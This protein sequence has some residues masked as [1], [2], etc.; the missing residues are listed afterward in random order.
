MWK[1]KGESAN[2]WLIWFASAGGDPDTP[3]GYTGGDWWIDQVVKIAYE[4]EENQITNLFGD[5]MEASGFFEPPTI[6]LVRRATRPPGC[7]VDLWVIEL[8]GDEEIRTAPEILTMLR[9]GTKLI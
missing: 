6:K 5:E 7:N 4:L 3:L 2:E 8:N 9:D 1:R